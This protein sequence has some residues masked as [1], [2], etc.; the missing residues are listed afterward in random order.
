[1]SRSNVGNDI[2]KCEGKE[3][4]EMEDREEG[5]VRQKNAF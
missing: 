5:N 2:S 3:Q 4:E 1:V